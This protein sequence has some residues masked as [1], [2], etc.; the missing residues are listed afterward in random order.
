MNIR[1][2]TLIVEKN[3]REILYYSLI[4]NFKYIFIELFI[5]GCKNKNKK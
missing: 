4:S 5:I 3:T 1:K 2:N